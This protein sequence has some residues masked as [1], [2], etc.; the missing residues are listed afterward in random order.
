MRGGSSFSEAELQGAFPRG[1]A[2]SL[3]LD[4]VDAATV[5]KLRRAWTGGLALAL[6]MAAALA[7]YLLNSHARHSRMLLRA[8]PESKVKLGACGPSATDDDTDYFTGKSLYEMENVPDTETCRA[9]CKGIPKCGAW[10]WGKARNV[11]GLTDVCFLKEL[12]NAEKVEKR[13]KQ[14]VVSGL[15][16]TMT[17]SDSPEGLTATSPVGSADQRAVAV[18]SLATSSLL[19]SSSTSVSGPS[20]LCFA[21]IIPASYEQDLLAMQFREHAGLFACDQYAVYSNVSLQVAPGVV[22]NAIK[23]DLK[24]DK[25]GEFGTAL[26]TDIFMVLWSNVIKDGLYLLHD[27]TVK[28]D[29]DTVFFPIRLRWVLQLHPEA[30]TGPGVYLNNCKFGMHGPLEVF[31]RRAVTSWAMGA[32]RCVRHFYQLCSGPCLWGEDMFIDQCMWKVLHVRRENEF[33]L[34]SEAHCDPRPG[35][36]SC[37]DPSQVAFHPYK[38]LD[39]Y[40]KCME[41]AG[42][43]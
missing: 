22:T 24:C 23:S 38:T 4:S 41:N 25:G 26:N 21:L 40:R 33:N 10:T 27:W 42:G 12:A 19:R 17:W 8:A 28:A 31:S 14:G 36:A 13:R 37:R 7:A 6:M 9:R 16:C 43:P 32:E 18:P 5:E 39:G 15:P 29:A 30:S 35:W 1:D 11:A 20:L 34:L 2:S 3:D